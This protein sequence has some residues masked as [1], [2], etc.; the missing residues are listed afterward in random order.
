MQ[1]WQFG[2]LN[3]D[4]VEGDRQRTLKLTMKVSSGLTTAPRGAEHQVQMVQAIVTTQM[5]AQIQSGNFPH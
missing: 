4:S 3:G 5:L 1:D 2:S